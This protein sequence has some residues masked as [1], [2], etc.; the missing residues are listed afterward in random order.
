[1]NAVEKFTA[2]KDPV[3]GC[4]KLLLRPAGRPVAVTV[5]ELV[6]PE[7]RPMENASLLEVPFCCTT[8]DEAER[9]I[10]KLLEGL[11]GFVTAVALAPP[12]PVR[13]ARPIRDAS[14]M[15]AAMA[16]SRKR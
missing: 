2:P 16:D 5:T 9:L 13:M 15:L 11:P 12:Q 7:V 1:M 6:S 10:A 4:V 3:P 14:P 8:S